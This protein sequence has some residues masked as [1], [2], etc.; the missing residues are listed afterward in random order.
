MPFKPGQSGNP[1]GRPKKE[2]TL[3]AILEKAGNVKHDDVTAKKVLADLLWEGATTG[4]VTFGDTPK[5]LDAQDWLGLVKFIYQHIDGP[6]KVEL[7]HSGET[8]LRVIYGDDGT[9]DPAA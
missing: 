4:R 2:R 3:T 9:S 1:K 6:S 7:E 5:P 8:V